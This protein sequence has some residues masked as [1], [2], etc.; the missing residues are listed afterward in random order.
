MGCSGFRETGSALELG[1]PGTPAYT[2]SCP[3]V[4]PVARPKGQACRENTWRA[5]KYI[6][7]SSASIKKRVVQFCCHGSDEV[8]YGNSFKDWKMALNPLII[9]IHTSCEAFFFYLSVPQHETPVPFE[10]TKWGNWYT[11]FEKCIYSLADS[12]VKSSRHFCGDISP[13][14]MGMLHLFP[15]CLEMGSRVTYL[16]LYSEIGELFRQAFYGL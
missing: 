3:P 13:W 7:T 15:S 16:R 2:Y 1:A 14:Q 10:D 4:A 8:P 11:C 5:W 12:L 9:L 6:T